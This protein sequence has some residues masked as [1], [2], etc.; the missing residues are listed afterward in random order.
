MQRVPE[1]SP[2][3]GGN[4]VVSELISWIAHERDAEWVAKLAV[5]RAHELEDIAYL[6]ASVREHQRHAEELAQLLRATRARVPIPDGAV[7]L[8]R[9]PHVIGALSEPDAVL[10][11]LRDLEG[12]RIVRYEERRRGGADPRHL[13]DVLLD[14]HLAAARVRWAWLARRSTRAPPPPVE[15]PR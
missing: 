2:Q 6:G 12:A 8:T 5:L 7:F 3:I 1:P 15:R 10:R 14:R 11:A 4:P 13:L 9:D